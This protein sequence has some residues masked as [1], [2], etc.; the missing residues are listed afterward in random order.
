MA[1]LRIF[2]V[3]DKVKPKSVPVSGASDISHPHA[4]QLEGAFPMGVSPVAQEEAGESREPDKP[5]VR[6]HLG[7]SHSTFDGQ[8]P[9]LWQSLLGLLLSSHLAPSLGSLSCS[10]G[11]LDMEPG[12]EHKASEQIGAAPHQPTN[13]GRGHSWEECQ[14]NGALKPDGVE[15]RGQPLSK[16]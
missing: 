14:G 2:P 15:C 4:L 8:G 3:F 12:Q 11:S 5:Q 9:A 6:C 7:P 10:S 13:L 1:I 16:L